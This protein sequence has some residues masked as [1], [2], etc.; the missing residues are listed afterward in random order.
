MNAPKRLYRTILRMYPEEFRL[1]VGPELL[2]SFDRRLQETARNA[3]FVFVVRELMDILRNLIAEWGS[4]LLGTG[5]TR[6][7]EARYTSD[8][9][10]GAS[11]VFVD[12]W[13][14][15][16]FALRLLRRNPAFAVVVTLTLG[17]TV[18]ANTTVFSVVNS[19]LLRPLDYPAPHE[20]VRVH[21]RF[22]PESGRDVPKFGIAPAEVLDYRD[23]SSAMADVGYY[24]VAGATLLSDGDFPSRLRALFTDDR[25][26][27]VLGVEPQI[28][29]WFSPEED[30]PDA[31]FT[32]VL[33]HSLWS[34]R[35]GEDPTVLGS[36]ILLSGIAAEVVG[37][38]PEGFTV[39]ESEVDIYLP[40]QYP[41]TFRGER[42]SHYLSAIGR[43]VTGQTAESARLESEG[44]QAAWVDEFEHPG[45]GHMLVFAPLQDDLL[46]PA[47][48]V[49]WMLL[50]AVGLVLLIATA[51][52]ANLLLARGESRM[53]EMG[54]RAS[55]GAGYAR[56]FR[57]MLAESA[58]LAFLGTSLGVAVAYV[59]VGA[60]RKMDP[61]TL[62]RA[63]SIALDLPVLA[64][65]VAVI[66]LVTILF[67]LAPALQ[68]VSGARTAA[69]GHTR[70][71]ASTSRRRFRETLVVAEVALSVVIV[72]GA[73]LLVRSFGELVSVDVGLQTENRLS[74]DL[75]VPSRFYEGDD[76]ARAVVGQISER[77]LAIPGVVGASYTSFL[78]FSGDGA[79]RNFTL[80]NVNPPESGETAWNAETAA[81]G[82][83]WIE[84]M[85]IPLIQGRT[86]QGS[87]GRETQLV[88]MISAEMARLF[89]PNDDPVGKRFGYGEYGGAGDGSDWV[90]IVGVVGDTRTVALDAGLQPQIYLLYDQT[91]RVYGDRGRNGSF[92]LEAA[93]DPLD[94]TAAVRQGVADVDP[95]LAVAD[96]NTLTARVGGTI[97]QPRL[98][99]TL[100]AGFGLI[101]L[102]LATVGIYG[103][104]SYSAARRTREIGIR[105]V[106][107][108]GGSGVVG[109]IVREGA[110]PALVG[111]GIGLSA[112]WVLASSLES[113]LFQVSA[114]DSGTFA[115]IAVT[116]TSV[117]VCAAWLP[118]RR[119][120]RVSPSAAL[121]EE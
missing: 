111:V 97:A 65:T 96:I 4:R 90:T 13:Q 120:A 25:L 66:G 86:F 70:T 95:R 38:M 33:S 82:H 3:R 85:G 94:L 18:G 53:A 112:F 77:L 63:G 61:T 71:T 60:V 99:A 62:P 109:M 40:Y 119:A 104:V 1:L 11:S 21:T 26:L 117:A 19:V 44:I 88:G 114:R 37:V 67:G 9:R 87:D 110:T 118:A 105:R 42:D 57:Q 52:V 69:S 12:T 79:R 28:G 80:E 39:P 113:L 64:F 121:R 32:A 15:V 84:T 27:S 59:G 47:R 2:A 51:N 36:T 22:L 100:M 24:M 78:P 108:A 81:V 107:G 50:A 54:I 48:A 6:G 49:L 23:A 8:R 103:V 93:T 58:T 45:P 68:A 91:G 16:G 89:W 5:A 10:G 7:S 106:L 73:G 35:F 14:D 56:I 72:L 98:A 41:E 46:G 75:S 29:R 92:V 17:I 55:L 43:L 30:E 76:D 102:L 101:A 115:V 31:S 74:F 20:L 34:T 116:F 83:D